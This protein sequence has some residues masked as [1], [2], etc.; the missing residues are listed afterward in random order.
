MTVLVI[1]S[2]KDRARVEKALNPGRSAVQTISDNL[3]RFLNS[4]KKGYVAAQGQEQHKVCG[5]DDVLTPADAADITRVV[6]VDSNPKSI[7]ATTKPTDFADKLRKKLKGCAS[8]DIS[9]TLLVSRQPMATVRHFSG[10]AGSFSLE[11]FVETVREE[12]RDAEFTVDAV[13][14]PL[15]DNE[16]N[17]TLIFIGEDNIK[18]EGFGDDLS[19]NT[20]G[21]DSLVD[22]LLNPES[23]RL[24][25][26]KEGPVLQRAAT[27]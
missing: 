27:A 22:A 3:F 18:I 19:I 25:Y 15:G 21:K 6:V 14:A 17:G 1:C 2:E 16:C 10:E 26:K 11:R 9:L 24:V 20:I 12:L 5:W 4:P 13:Y 7:C 8:S 23:S